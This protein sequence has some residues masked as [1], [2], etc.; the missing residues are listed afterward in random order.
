M[1]VPT[2]DSILD[3]FLEPGS[4][5]DAHNH[6]TEWRYQNHAL[7]RANTLYSSGGQ[8]NFISRS[9]AT[10][11]HGSIEIM[12]DGAMELRFN[13]RFKDIANRWRAGLQEAPPPLLSTIL[14]PVKQVPMTWTGSDYCAR[15]ITLT[16]Q[17]TF[18]LSPAASPNEP[19]IWNIVGDQ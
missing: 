9:G 1:S 13:A 4:T 18:L 19:S 12:G 3:L 2:Q 5:I 6:M 14:Y 11:W 8:L 10:G 7:T 17:R 15:Q 16:R